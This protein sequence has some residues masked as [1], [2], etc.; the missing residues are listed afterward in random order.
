[1]SGAGMVIFSLLPHICILPIFSIPELSQSAQQILAESAL[2]AGIAPDIYN[3]EGPLGPEY[4]HVGDDDWMDE[5]AEAGDDGMQVGHDA[6]IVSL[7]RYVLC[8]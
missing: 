5:D 1:M 6:E 2:E 7:L 3:Q 4:D 8:C